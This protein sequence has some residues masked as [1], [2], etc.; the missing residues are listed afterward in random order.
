MQASRG[1]CT[2]P[3]PR[4][5]GVSIFVQDDKL[6]V[7]YNAFDDHLIVESDVEVPVGDS[8]LGVH[9]RRTGSGPE[10]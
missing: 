3:A 9:V 1:S 7:D 4:T 2:Q 6:V 10:R 5:P 8:E